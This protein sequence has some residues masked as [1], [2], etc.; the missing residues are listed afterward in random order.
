MRFIDIPKFT[1]N[2]PYTTHIG[3]DALED[4]LERFANQHRLNLNPDFQRI[5]RWTQEEQIKYVEYILK[6]GISGRD[7]YFNMAGWGD[8][9][10]GELELVDGKQRLQ[11]CKRIPLW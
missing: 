7:I 3:W 2:A 4:H 8:K 11:G 10:N 9:Y 1:K 5:H 6:G